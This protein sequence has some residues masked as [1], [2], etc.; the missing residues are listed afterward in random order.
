MSHKEESSVAPVPP[1][2]CDGQ[3]LPTKG[4]ASSGDVDIA[5]AIIENTEFVNIDPAL[6]GRTLRKIDTVI[7]PLLA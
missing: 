7:L 3:A 6:T 4:E 5:L 1:D 2:D